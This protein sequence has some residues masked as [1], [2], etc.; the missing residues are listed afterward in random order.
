MIHTFSNRY[1]SSHPAPQQPPKHF[2]WSGYW[3]NMCDSDLVRSVGRLHNKPKKEYAATL[4]IF[5]I[6]SKSTQ[7]SL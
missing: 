7:R 3:K 4:S 1:P 2:W 6:K 5:P